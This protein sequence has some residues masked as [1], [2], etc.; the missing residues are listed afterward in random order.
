M[1]WRIKKFAP[2]VTKA[3]VRFFFTGLKNASIPFQTQMILQGA[4]GHHYRVDGLVAPNIIIE[5]DG[6]SH[7]DYKQQL[8]D[9]KRDEDLRENGY[10]VIRFR[11]WEVYKKLNSCVATV[12]TLR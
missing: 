6:A 1:T 11:N 4:S 2:K 3:E 5:I 9:A 12:K 10:V 7:D 8:M